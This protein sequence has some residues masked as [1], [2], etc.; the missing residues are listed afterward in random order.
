[1]AGA[2]NGG[3][4]DP[5][6]G[7][8]GMYGLYAITNFIWTISLYVSNRQVYREVLS[9]DCFRYSNSRGRGTRALA[10]GKL[11]ENEFS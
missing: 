1:M 3:W 9:A 4:S 5:G 10:G 2:A 11:Q 6:L 7:E 8:E